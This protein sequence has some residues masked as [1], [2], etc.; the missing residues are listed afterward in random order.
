MRPPSRILRNWRNPSPRGPSRLPSGTAHVRERELARVG[1]APAD[2]LHRRRDL[3]AGRAVRHDD[4]RDLV[5]ARLRRDR[6]GPGDVRARVGDE[7]LRAVH[8]PL[9]H[10][11][12]RRVVRV[13]PASEPAPGSVRPNAARPPA[14]GEIGE[15]LAL[16]L[17][18]AEQEDRHRPE[19]G[20]RGD[21]D[22]HR[23][24]DPRQLLDRDR[25]RERVGAGAAVL[26]RDR[27][28]HEPE[29]GEARDDVVREAVLAVELLGD[30]RD[31]RLAR[32]RARS[33]AAVRARRRGRSSSFGR[34]RE[35]ASSTTRRTP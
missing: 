26:L 7:D 18:G 11:G 22:R 3:E 33:S 12:A 24:V 5:L 25:V 23:R 27:D 21:G 30:R 15:P 8:D 35:D 4:V 20:V 28:A 31:L 19:R 14:R 9:S 17:L 13:A 1:R 34:G 29:L 32:T 6:G 16:L 2:L 10:R